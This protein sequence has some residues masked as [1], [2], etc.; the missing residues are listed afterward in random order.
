MEPLAIV[1][2]LL[3]GFVV[4]GWITSRRVSPALGMLAVL[5]LACVVSFLAV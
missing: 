5:F 4:D 2:V 1:A 3:G